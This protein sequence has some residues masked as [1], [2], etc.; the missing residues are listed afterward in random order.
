MADFDSLASSTSRHLGLNAPIVSRKGEDSH[1]HTDFD[2]Y[3]LPPGQAD[4]FFPTDF[5]L[6]K[7][8]YKSAT[9]QTASVMK[10]YQF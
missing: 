10:T 6:L 8:M 1:N 2:S 4:I 9:G 7:Q 5:H 3:L